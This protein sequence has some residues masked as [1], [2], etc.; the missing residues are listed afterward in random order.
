MLLVWT[1]GLGLVGKLPLRI[2]WM[3]RRSAINWPAPGAAVTMVPG[4]TDGGGSGLSV[5]KSGWICASLEVGVV[6]LLRRGISLNEVAGE[7]LRERCRECGGWRSKG[8]PGEGDLLPVGLA[9]IVSRNLVG[10]GLEVEEFMTVCLACGSTAEV[11]HESNASSDVIS[12]SPVPE[13]NDGDLYDIFPDINLVFDEIGRT[14]WVR[15]ARSASR[16]SEPARLRPRVG[17]DSTGSKA[18]NA[19]ESLP[20]DEGEVNGRDVSCISDEL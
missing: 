3:V 17:A 2:L 9:G 20:L 10:T 8:N 11:S 13:S 14:T 15:E 6:V 4:V 12:L 18:G 16:A 7:W 1:S 19:V 5:R